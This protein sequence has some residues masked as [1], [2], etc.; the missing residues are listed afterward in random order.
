VESKNYSC[1]INAMFTAEVDTKTRELLQVPD[2]ELHVMYIVVG[3][4]PREVPV[5]RSAR[6]D[7]ESVLNIIG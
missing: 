6:L 7:V 5:C 2:Y 3:N 1:L 4:F